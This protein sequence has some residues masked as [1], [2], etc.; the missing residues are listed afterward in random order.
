[1]LERSV[2]QQLLD[3]PA[4]TSLVG[5]DGIHFT[6][7]VP[8]SEDSKYITVHRISTTHQRHQS[9]G[10]GECHSRIQIDCVAEGRVDAHDIY[11]A[12]RRT[13]DNFDGT[14]GSGSYTTEVDTC[15]LID[16]SHE[17]QPPTE[18]SQTGPV[19]HRMD[20]DIWHAESA[21]TNF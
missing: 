11:D 21:V 16:D 19:V 1:M 9:G 18:G 10:S 4:V 7:R 17:T 15:A 20:F 6:G 2:I 5:T 12:V 8:Q 13:L 14:M 3:T